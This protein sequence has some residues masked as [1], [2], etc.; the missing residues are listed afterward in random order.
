MKT[1]LIGLTV[2]M[3]SGCGAVRY[4]VTQPTDGKPTKT[5]I[6]WDVVELQFNSL[7]KK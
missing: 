6:Q 2:L 4:R 5:E 1:L 3:L 7:W